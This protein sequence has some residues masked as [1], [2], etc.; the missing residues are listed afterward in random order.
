[1]TTR[2]WP[3]IALLLSL[4][5]TACDSSGLQTDNKDWQLL[6]AGGSI[7][8][9]SSSHRSP[10]LSERASADDWPADARLG[11]RYE[12]SRDIVE[13][14]ID[15]LYW[16][17]EREH[18]RQHLAGV[19]GDALDQD[20][21]T[22]FGSNRLNALLPDELSPRERARARDL[23]EIFQARP[24]RPNHRL[25]EIASPKHTREPERPSIYR[26]FV[27]M[28]ARQAGRTQPR[29]LVFTSAARDAMSPVDY[30]LSAFSESGATARW[31]VADPA[32]MSALHAGECDALEQWRQ[33]TSNSWNRASVYPDLA[34]E[35]TALCE[36]PEKLVESMQWA[37]G[38]F[39]NGGDQSRHRAT[40]I[41]PSG[42]QTEA[43]RVMRER[44]KNAELVVGGTS[45]GTA[46][47]TAA[48]IPMIASGS[49]RAALTGKLKASPPPP[50]D[51]VIHNDCPAGTGPETL[52]W[53]AQGGLGLFS[54]GLLDTHYGERGRPARSV[55]LAAATG[56][57]RAFGVDETTAL[58]V[59]KDDNQH[60]HFEVMGRASALIM[61]FGQAELAAEADGIQAKTIWLHRLTDGAAMRLDDGGLQPVTGGE[62]LIDNCEAGSPPGPL[63]SNGL[64][65]AAERM[66]CETLDRITLTHSSNGS[67]WDFKFNKRE[68]TQWLA[69]DAKGLPGWFHLEMHIEKKTS[70]DRESARQ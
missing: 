21:H 42:E 19:L 5:L 44:F 27:E 65:A 8:V 24:K 15:P 67:R 69:A 4:A 2:L 30:Y 43:L 59:R 56:T 33:A 51:C 55:A 37:D 62:P 60:Y 3:L 9:C 17:K 25:R 11:P 38:V 49:P 66:Q 54:A 57:E 14:I 22:Q 35:Q 10:C 36:T 53:E 31:A 52:T 46:V 13:D 70:D 50:P 61:E 26:Q 45:A 6:L 40:L 1:M 48:G 68:H 16:D 29:I 41:Q 58:L 20:E 47:Q 7:S 39:F 28:A 34:A 64:A 18:I 32:V 63:A 12:L 23:L